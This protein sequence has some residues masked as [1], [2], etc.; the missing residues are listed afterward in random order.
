MNI[1]Y[2]IKCYLPLSIY[3]NGYLPLD[4]KDWIELQTNDS[5]SLKIGMS[6][7][8][9]NPFLEGKTP[10]EYSHTIFPTEFLFLSITGY[11]P[12][13]IV[14]LLKKS[15]DNNELLKEFRLAIRDIIKQIYSHLVNHLRNHF[16]QY[17]NSDLM[18]YDETYINDTLWLDNDGNWNRVFPKTI[19][20]KS[21][22]VGFGLTHKNWCELEIRLKNNSN[23]SMIKTMMA[24][25]KAHLEM[26]NGRMA[27]VEAV[28][29]LEATIKQKMPSLLSVFVNPQLPEQLISSAIEG[30]GLRL[31]AK[32][33]FEHLST[34]LKLNPQQCHECLEAIECRNQII[35]NRMK[36]VSNQEAQKFVIAIDTII[37]SLENGA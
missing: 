9:L 6:R 14:E 7:E 20:I 5:V 13:E 24:N 25:S 34:K 26:N 32:I 36:N 23:V 8:I 12:E 29:A 4:T 37:K 30:M 15:S 18:P 10:Q 2:E 35:H 27:V 19:L 17:W 31:T 11:W 3:W 1:K 16:G 28:C 22:I 33:I 21:Q